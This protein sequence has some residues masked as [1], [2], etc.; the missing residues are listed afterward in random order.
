MVNTIGR[1]VLRLDLLRCALNRALQKLPRG[2]A[3]PLELWS[4]DLTYGRLI[5]AA[6]RSGDGREVERLCG[7]ASL[8]RS[9][10]EDELTATLAR[11]Y[12]SR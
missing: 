4:D 3:I 9:L 11:V 10:L 6:E 5:E 1:L 7:E 12:P 8:Y 2:V